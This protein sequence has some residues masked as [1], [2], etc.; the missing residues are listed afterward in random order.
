MYHFTTTPKKVYF[1]NVI[2]Y[3]LM[4]LQMGKFDPGNPIIV[5]ISQLRKTKILNL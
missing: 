2:Q 1:E 3:Y 5:F 4:V